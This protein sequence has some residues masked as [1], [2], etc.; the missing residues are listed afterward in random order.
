MSG[1]IFNNAGNI[2]TSKNK[3]YNFSRFYTTHFI[4]LSDILFC[5]M[6][7]ELFQ[8]DKRAAAKDFLIKEIKCC[9]TRI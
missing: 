3:I 4:P 8:N 5:M 2:E 9:D 1:N 6:R 7:R